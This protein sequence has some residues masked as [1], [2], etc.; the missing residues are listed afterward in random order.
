[1]CVCVVNVASTVSMFVI[2]AVKARDIKNFVLNFDS[3]IFH[4]AAATSPNWK[5]RKMNAFTVLAVVINI[6]GGTFC[7][8]TLFF[9]FKRADFQGMEL[10]T[11]MG[12]G[13]VA[14]LFLLFNPHLY[15]MGFFINHY[16]LE[17]TERVKIWKV[18]L[19]ESKILKKEEKRSKDLMDHM[20]EGARLCQVAEELN[21]TFSPL[22]LIEFG[23]FLLDGILYGFGIAVPIFNGLD[24]EIKCFLAACHGFL[25][26]LF[27]GTIFLH[28]HCGQ[29]L[30]NEAKG[31][32][33]ELE[34]LG[35][36]K[37]DSLQA[38][39]RYK[40]LS[41]LR[42]IKEDIKI[43]PFGSVEASYASFVSLI[44]VIITYVIVLLQFMVSV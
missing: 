26:I 34:E 25:T 9:I 10:W 27:F 43:A 8:L 29:T 18:H 42:R 30:I 16:V 44:A 5:R 32:R 20:Q 36:E 35:L 12:A 41:L 6:V 14:A 17:L 7:M 19:K 24:N 37:F 13:F 3:A 1:M 31:A 23:F 33:R 39:S 22:V 40:F 15:G 11:V 2:V 28:G 21:V 38:S 4:T